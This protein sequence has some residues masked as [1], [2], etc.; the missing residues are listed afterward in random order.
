MMRRRVSQKRIVS[1]LM[2]VLFCE[3]EN[4]PKRRP[5]RGWLNSDTVLYS[6]NKKISYA[7]AIF[8]DQH[9]NA[10][11][12]WTCSDFLADEPG[13]CNITQNQIHPIAILWNL[14]NFTWPLSSC[15]LSKTQLLYKMQRSSLLASKEK[16]SNPTVDTPCRCAE[17]V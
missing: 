5:D 4:L 2:L 1:L 12:C 13:V 7:A 11:H 3:F 8:W 9:T 14:I 6:I 15:S 17:E 10:H 16:S